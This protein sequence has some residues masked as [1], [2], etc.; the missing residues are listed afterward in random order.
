VTVAE[1]VAVTGGSRRSGQ[2]LAGP[3]S[4]EYLEPFGRHTVL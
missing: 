2:G 4:A 1:T 3:G